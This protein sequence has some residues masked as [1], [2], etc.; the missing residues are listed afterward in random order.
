[1]TEG[2]V[3]PFSKQSRTAKPTKNEP[4]ECHSVMCGL[5]MNR[6]RS[7]GQRGPSSSSIF[8]EISHERPSHYGVFAEISVPKK[9]SKS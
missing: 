1:M 2:V 9:K 3:M 8:A 5:S 7:L 6:R 4:E